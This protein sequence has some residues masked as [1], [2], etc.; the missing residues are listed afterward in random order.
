MDKRIKKVLVVLLVVILAWI[1]CGMMTVAAKALEPILEEAAE[2]AE[3]PVEAQIVD[4]VAEEN[5]EYT[6]VFLNDDG[7]YTARFYSAPIRFKDENDELIDIDTSFV[8]LEGRSKAGIKEGSSYAYKTKATEVETYL[9]E[10]ISTQN[11]VLMVHDKYTVTMV[12]IEL[13]RDGTR[14]AVLDEAL[15]KVAAASLETEPVS[16]VQAPEQVEEAE[17]G[18]AGAQK[19]TKTEEAGLS[20]PAQPEAAREVQLTEETTMALEKYERLEVYDK[21]EE[22]SKSVVVEKIETKEAIQVEEEV[23]GLYDGLL[24]PEEKLTKIR[25][26]G[27][28]SKGVKKPVEYEYIALSDGIKENIIL[29]EYTGNNRFDFLLTVSNAYPEMT[30]YGA[31]MIKDDE[32]DEQIGVIPAPYMTDASEEGGYSTEAYYEIL[33]TADGFILT[34]VVDENYLTD[35]ARVYPV[36]VDPS[37]SIFTGSSV[38]QDAYVKSH[39]PYRDTNFYSSGTKVMPFGFGSETYNGYSYNGYSR[40]YIHFPTLMSAI[41]DKAVVKSCFRVWENGENSS[42]YATMEFYRVTSSWSP[43]TITWNNQPSV[44]GFYSTKNTCT[45]QNL[46]KHYFDFGRILGYWSGYNSN[47]MTNNGYPYYGV[48]LRSTVESSSTRNYGHVFGSRT[49]ATGYRPYLD[50]TYVAVPKP[51]LV[52]TTGIT[53]SSRANIVLSFPRYKSLEGT[54]EQPNYDIRIT[55]SGGGTFKLYEIPYSE[56]IKYND[57]TYRWD[58]SKAKAIFGTVKGFPDDGSTVLGG[59]GKYDIRLAISNTF[60]VGTYSPILTVQ[61]PDSTAPNAVTSVTASASQDTAYVG[62]SKVAVSYP[63]AADNPGSISSGIKHYIVQLVPV[64]NSKVSTKTITTTSTSYTF[65]DLSKDWA[66]NAKVQVQTVDNNNNTSAIK[67]STTFAIKDYSPPTAPTVTLTPSGWSNAEEVNVKWSGIGVGSANAGTIRVKYQW[68]TGSVSNPSYI[69]NVESLGNNSYGSSGVDISVPNIEGELLLFVWGDD[70]AQQGNKGH[71]VFRRD[72]TLPTVEITSPVRGT[73]LNDSVAFRGTITDNRGIAEWKLEVNNGSSGSYNVLASG[74]NAVINGQ[75]CIVNIGSLTWYKPYT[76]RLTVTD[77]AG[78]STVWS[79][80]YMRGGTGGATIANNFV[81]DKELTDGQWKMARY[82]ETLTLSPRLN[83]GSVP[84]G[85]KA[86]FLNGRLHNTY[87]SD[88]AIEMDLSDPAYYADGSMQ[89]AVVRINDS[90]GYSHYSSPVVQRTLFNEDL[91][92]H[93]I[94]DCENIIDGFQGLWVDDWVRP[95]TILLLEEEIIGGLAGLYLETCGSAGGGA[96]ITFSLSINGSA[97]ID[98]TEEAWLN[99]EDLAELGFTDLGIVNRVK[100]KLTM[101]NTNGGWTELYG[102]TVKVKHFS[103][104]AEDNFEVQL[105]NPASDLSTR[106]NINYT[107]LAR[108]EEATAED[109]IDDEMTYN[110][111]RFDAGEAQFDIKDKEPIQSGITAPYWYDYNLNY[112]ESFDYV[113]TASAR[114]GP[115]AHLRESVVS[116][117]ATSTVV[118]E[119]ELDKRLGLQNYWDYSVTQTSFGVGYTEM[120]QG[121]FAYIVEDTALPGPQLGLVIRRTYNSQATS[122]TAMGAGWDFSFNTMLLREYTY[123]EE[124]GKEVVSAMLLKDGDGTIHRFA[125]N[126]AG[127]FDTPPGIQM[128]LTY[129]TAQKAYKIERYDGIVYLFNESNQINRMED[130]TGDYV[131][132][133]YNAKGNL[134]KV[135]NMAGNELT[136]TYGSGQTEDILTGMTLP[137]GKVVSYFY[138]DGQLSRINRGISYYNNV[139]DTLD[140]VPESINVRYYYTD[141]GHLS[142]IQ[143]PGMNNATGVNTIYSV[144]YE[145][146]S[147]D[148]P[149]WRVNRIALPNGESFTYDYSLSDGSTT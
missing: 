79:A 92:L 38:V 1:N 50:V 149:M 44:T 122:E 123:D 94:R 72:T 107:V 145:L 64:S 52:S 33:E 135:R 40:T 129:D 139:T 19:T 133:T 18:E 113:V 49:G 25:Y 45:G 136:F 20:E 9:P 143:E 59:N 100:V 78:N 13:D 63:A 24:E 56:L 22:E 87:A 41:K 101:D 134:I 15:R 102:A 89:N 91:G 112:G 147:E 11:P 48:M 4:V 51:T 42:P 105:I 84:V 96:S 111:Y 97:Y 128:Q 7:S 115:Q 65:R 124:A 88:E 125:A 109:A 137:D 55:G 99:Y 57:T 116:N 54:P 71:A 17:E 46:K 66:G 31:I 6:T 5:D 117:S 106:A 114:F 90:D 53:N 140:S 21:G 12:P 60:S 95:G 86:L 34:V 16:S 23:V 120:S 82:N 62:K 77:V 121:N 35:K 130:K 108:W 75:I 28:L 37:Y 131:N 142:Q 104:S 93:N 103:Y 127:G 8:A 36:V 81:I 58:S 43:S 110:V 141:E 67:I 80:N 61:M 2:K 26:E 29:N 73:L 3:E 70:S 146:S 126:A 148:L 118:D 119:N 132:Y 138:Q 76:Y 39:T 47:G 83:T 85:E 27:E 144:V 69:G 30:E 74:S 14:A 98:V 32:T 68:A 10:R